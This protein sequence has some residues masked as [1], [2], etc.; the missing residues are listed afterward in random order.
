MATKGKNTHGKRAGGSAKNVQPAAK[1]ASA[2][3]A[4]RGIRS[5]EDYR[6]LMCALMGDVIQG[7]VTPE[8][9]NAACNA[10]RGLVRMVELEYKMAT[11]QRHTERTVPFTRRVAVTGAPQAQRRL[12]AV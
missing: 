7:S 12:K 4:R 11:S 5:S 8:V 9:V 10:G 3:V 2:E 6:D 1:G